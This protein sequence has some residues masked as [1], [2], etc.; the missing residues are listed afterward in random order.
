MRLL[1]KDVLIAKLEDHKKTALVYKDRE[2]YYNELIEN[3]NS[4]SRLLETL[5]DQKVAIVCENRPE[6]VYALYA[7]WQRGSVAIPIDYLSTPEEISY[8]LE[9]S[10]PHVIFC[11]AETCQKVESALSL[12]RL[13]TRIYN[14]DSVILPKANENYIHR[15]IDDVA[16]IFYTSGTTG[17]PKGVMITFGNLMS[18][19]EAIKEMNIVG[20]EDKTLA[21]LPFHHSYPF[22]T[23][24]LVP[25]QI[26]ASIVFLEK[27]SSDVLLQTLQKYKITVLVGVPRLYQ[28]LHQKMQE[29]IEES[30]FSRILYKV[31]SSFPK[32]LRRVAFKR[33]HDAFGGRLKFMVSGGAKLPLDTARFLDSL[34]F[35][36]L[37]GYG[38]T[39]TSPIVSFNPPHKVKL[40]SVGVPI[41]GVQIKID[42]DGEL[43]IR[44]PNVMLGYYNKPEET[45]K[46]FKD[47]WLKTGD[48]A[49]LDDEGYIYIE[50]RKKEIIVLA[51]GKNVNPEELEN[52]ILKK[53]K[54]VKECA[55]L[56]VDGSLKALLYLDESVVKERGI[57]N[58]EEY[59]RWNVL[60]KVN[61]ELPPWKRITGFKIISNEL[62]KTRLGKIKRYKLLD[63]YKHA[64]KEDL[65]KPKAIETPVAKTLRDYLGGYTNR[66]VYGYEHIELDLGLDS[67]GKIELLSFIEK[68]FGLSIQEEELSKMLSLNQLIHYIQEHKEREELSSVNW[69][70]ILRESKPFELAKWNLPFQIGRFILYTFFKLYNRLHVEG[71][72]NLPQGPCILAPNHASY[73]DGFVLTCALPKDFALKTYFLGEEVYFRGN[74]RSLFAKFAH[75]I[76]INLNKN[77]KESMQKAAYVLISGKNL[78]IFPEGARTRDGNLLPFKK[79]FAILSK[80]LKV[81]VV[82]VA[83]IGTYESMSIKDRFPKPRKIKVIFLKS[84]HPESKSYEEIV[85]ETERSIRETIK[86]SP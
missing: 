78:V 1:E 2:I 66:E 73:L 81:P 3:V 40:G 63:I 13:E 25:L 53:D 56:E 22:M 8:I 18:N 54:L 35:E 45:K 61:L 77:L 60:D 15:N 41:K 24:L 26:G 74:L 30:L 17:N 23:T 7:I 19:I 48:L 70:T 10:K 55:I 34:G 50:G 6:W 21:L 44:G 46:A 82:P 42:K 5:P 52:L 80:E 49:H 11:S 47:G 38:L 4:Y 65:R 57:V 12:V 64:Q 33:V 58:L 16:V 31:F 76:T 39:E 36:I 67:L 85:K 43:L 59:V 20:K 29:K 79:G 27:L 28:L 71:L 72:E 86:G 37:E 83:V 51:G 69:S 32:P 62:P 9:D 68:T 14:I 75:V 84:V